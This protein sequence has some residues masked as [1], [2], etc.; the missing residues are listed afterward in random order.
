MEGLV[1]RVEPFGCGGEQAKFE[2]S[3]AGLGEICGLSWA[4]DGAPG[5]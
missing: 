4:T 5:A 1:H 2:Q 3:L